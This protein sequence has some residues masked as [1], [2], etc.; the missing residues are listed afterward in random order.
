M[1]Q[2]YR[3]RTEE[4]VIS[5]GHMAERCQAQES[6]PVSLAKRPTWLIQAAGSWQGREKEGGGVLMETQVTRQIMPMAP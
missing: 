3:T 1:K 5:Q 4:G 6:A 2:P